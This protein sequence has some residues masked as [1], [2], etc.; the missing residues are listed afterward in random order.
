MVE[1]PIGGMSKAAVLC[2]GLF[3]F[4]ANDANFLSARAILIILCAIPASAASTRPSLSRKR[5]VEGGGIRPEIKLAHEGAG[6][7]GAVHAIHPAVFPFHR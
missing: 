1:V 3:R 5:G 2:G 4:H 6:F 7:C